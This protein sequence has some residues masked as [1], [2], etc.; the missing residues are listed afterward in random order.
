M[1][2]GAAKASTL[3]PCSYHARCYPFPAVSTPSELGC[4]FRF[5]KADVTKN[6]LGSNGPV[7]TFQGPFAQGPLTSPKLGSVVPNLDSPSTSQRSDI[8]AEDTVL[9]VSP[10][11]S[12]RSVDSASSMKS[13]YS[14]LHPASVSGG[15]S[16]HSRRN[17]GAGDRSN[18]FED[19]YDDVEIGDRSEREDASL[20]RPDSGRASHAH[21][22]SDNLYDSNAVE[23][24][25]AELEPHSVWRGL[26][27]S[28]AARLGHASESLRDK[29][30][31][32]YAE[33]RES[34]L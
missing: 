4:R 17:S 27:S 29:L 10:L 34:R 32:K 1:C 11:H 12:A 30:R 7:A 2:T 33:Y 9:D 6:R 18:M 26:R 25:R 19:V 24:E 16:V 23:L 20:L 28:A 21:A 3:L 8:V 15:Q 5:H 14:T 13:A 22:A 31:G